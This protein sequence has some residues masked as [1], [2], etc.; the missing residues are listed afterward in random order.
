L[1]ILVNH[2]R[3]TTLMT[4]FVFVRLLWTRFTNAIS[5]FEACPQEYQPTRTM[6]ILWSVRRGRMV[7]TS[8]S[9]PKGRWFESLQRHGAVYVSRIP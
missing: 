7:R 8:D 2:R 9:Q 1:M 4:R 6:K 3:T 5:C